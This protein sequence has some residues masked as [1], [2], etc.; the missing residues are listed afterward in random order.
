MSRDGVSVT[1]GSVAL[2]ALIAAPGSPEISKHS[3]EPA[4]EAR[5]IHDGRALEPSTERPSQVGEPFDVSQQVGCDRKVV[6]FGSRHELEEP[7]IREEA[8][9][10]A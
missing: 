5:R 2:F 10:A 1:Q 3:L 9:A 4:H 8:R 6:R 7:G